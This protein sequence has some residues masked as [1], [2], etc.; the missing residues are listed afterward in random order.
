MRCFIPTYLLCM[1]FNLVQTKMDYSVTL[2]ALEKALE[3]SKFGT[4]FEKCLG[5]MQAMH[6]TVML[7]WQVL[8][9]IQ[10]TKLTIFSLFYVMRSTSI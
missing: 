1:T 7:A 8:C 6:T 3:F 10:T 2:L 5:A 9:V 4:N